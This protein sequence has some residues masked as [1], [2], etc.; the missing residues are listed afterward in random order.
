MNTTVDMFACTGC[1]KRLS[2][3]RSL[4]G[5]LVACP[6]CGNIFVMP[7]TKSHDRTET[8]KSV[9]ISAATETLPVTHESL[10]SP[11]IIPDRPRPA[12][13]TI[14]AVMGIIF[15][16]IVLL[17]ALLM[18]AYLM[19]FFDSF[20]DNHK[21]SIFE[22]A[23]WVARCLLIFCFLQIS[24][25]L[26]KGRKTARKAFFTL[27]LFIMLLEV[28]KIATAIHYEKFNFDFQ[29][30]PFKMIGITYLVIGFTYLVIGVL[31]LKSRRVKNWF[32]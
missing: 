28:A 25:G 21:Q 27:A 20:P 12:G 3:I 4:I 32:D 2:R 5:S 11:Y 19:N 13:V 24:I 22:L 23:G 8:E 16:V 14:I 26:L 10:I 1:G 30:E 18:I 9:A 29:F 6:Y 15:S 7:H 17:T 31:Y